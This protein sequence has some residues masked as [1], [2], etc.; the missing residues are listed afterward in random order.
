[1]KKTAIII[2]ALAVAGSLGAC[3]K[4]TPPAAP[5]PPPVAPEPPPPAPP[6]PKAEVAPQ[7]D[8]YTRLRSMSAE[9]IDKM[10]LL[11]EVFFDFDRSDVRDSER[12]ALQKNADVLKRFDFLR[13]TVEG[14]CDERG[15]VEYN[16]ALGE[17]RSRAAHDYLA[18]LG[19]PADRLKTVSYGKEVPVCSD[20]NE[21]CWQ[22]NRR[23]HFTITG[24]AK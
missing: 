22:R 10:G 13:V 14:H 21:S 6:P 16:L 11:A 20:S 18:S 19:V 23:A 5:A 12:A 15:T 4:K 1:M 7:V 3:G 2:L 24:K 9:E 8:E 17:R